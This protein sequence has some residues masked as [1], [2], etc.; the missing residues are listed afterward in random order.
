M[1]VWSACK[2]VTP[3]SS[4]KPRPSSFKRRRPVDMARKKVNVGVRLKH[5]QSAHLILAAVMRLSGHAHDRH[6]RVVARPRRPGAGAGANLS[7][8]EQMGP[9]RELGKR[10]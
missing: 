2:G 5:F 3:Q 8:P 9:K 6:A 7:S 1:N 4:I 10:S